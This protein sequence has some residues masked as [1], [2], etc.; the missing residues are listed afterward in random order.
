MF[1]SFCQI[2]NR[3]AARGTDGRDCPA[4]GE[5][6]SVDHLKCRNEAKPAKLHICSGTNLKHLVSSPSFTFFLGGFQS[7][8]GNAK[9]CKSLSM[10][11]ALY[12]A[13]LIYHVHHGSPT[14][15]IYL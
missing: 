15:P 7:C 4:P 11:R 1:A 2:K 3:E 14:M 5:A 12:G 10:Q 8:F 6:P 9:L 13:L